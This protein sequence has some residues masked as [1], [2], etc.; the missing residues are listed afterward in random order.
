MGAGRKRNEWFRLSLRR[1]AIMGRI[2]K[3]LALLVFLLM[4]TAVGWTAETTPDKQLSILFTHDM[5][6]C[7]LPHQ[8]FT[9]DK[10]KTNRGGH[11]KPASLIQT[12]RALKK[13]KAI[14]VDA[15]DFSMGTPFH[16]AF[17]THAFELQLMGKM[18]YDV[19]T[20][21]N[22]DFDFHPDGLAKALDAA[23]TKAKRLATMVASN[24]VFSKNDPEDRLLKQSFRNF[25]AH[26][27]TV[28]ERSGLRIG[29]FGILGKDAAE[30]AP[31]AKPLTFADPIQTSRKM[32][33]ILRNKEKVDVVIC[34]SHAGTSPDKKR[35][36]DEILA[37]EVPG[38]DIII[39][40]HTHT[41][42]PQPIV[43]G[44]TII[45]SSG[46]HSSYLGMQTVAYDAKGKDVKIVS[47]QLKEVTGD[48]PNDQAIAQ[49]IAASKDFVNK[50]YLA[51][52][53]P[54]FEQAIAESGFD[55][56]PLFSPYY[57]PRR[58]VWET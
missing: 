8:D 5:H 3:S 37:R 36:E 47:C 34:L 46:C 56:E 7:F 28:L 21:G 44:K 38:I 53:A 30:D 4:F 25:P 12:Y 33:N 22:H 23:K 18:G 43:I 42:L 20:F 15:G 50:N 52:Y 10:G 16:T 41:N 17:M 40:G 2:G 51:S 13:D 39:S 19:I 11:A 6:S 26:E 14:I 57:H 49:N 35:S 27:Y 1:S 29:L 31:L 48:I 32:V 24:A 54:S 55:L 58:W 45:V 9:T